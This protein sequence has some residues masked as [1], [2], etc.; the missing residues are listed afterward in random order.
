M[1]RGPGWSSGDYGLPLVGAELDLR[2]SYYCWSRG[3]Y[4]YQIMILLRPVLTKN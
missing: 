1:E 3:N 4:Y 2:P